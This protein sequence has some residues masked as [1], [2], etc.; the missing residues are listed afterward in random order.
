M[1]ASNGTWFSTLTSISYMQLI[2]II[3]IKIF[4]SSYVTWP[5][6]SN[7]PHINILDLSRPLWIHKWLSSLGLQPCLANLYRLFIGMTSD[8][9]VCLWASD[10]KRCWQKTTTKSMPI[11]VH[12]P[13][14]EKIKSMAESSMPVLC[15]CS[16]PLLLQLPLAHRQRRGQMGFSFWL[17]AIPVCKL[18][19]LVLSFGNENQ[20][21]ALQQ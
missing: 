7:F 4:W 6:T 15:F 14:M 16:E 21:Q 17:I 12:C 8:V 9:N 5:N 11:K 2:W 13:Q 19:L 20:F 1:V 18:H 10:F 3:Y